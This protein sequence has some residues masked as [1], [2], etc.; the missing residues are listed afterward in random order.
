[1]ASSASGVAVT[2]ST[3][4]L[5]GTQLPSYWDNNQQNVLEG[6]VGSVGSSIEL[7]TTGTG[8]LI[9]YDA[10]GSTLWSYITANINAADNQ[11]LGFWM[12]DAADLLYVVTIDTDTTPDT[13]RLSSINLAG[14]IVNI[15]ND[16]PSVEFATSNAY[17][18]TNGMIQPDGSGGF[19]IIKGSSTAGNDEFAVMD[20]SGTFTTS[21]A[22]IT[23]V[24]ANHGIYGYSYKTDNGYWLYQVTLNSS[25]FHAQISISNE[26]D[27][28]PALLPYN[29][30]NG[31]AISTDSGFIAWRDYVIG[32]DGSSNV[33]RGN[34]KF[35]KAQINAFATQLAAYTGVKI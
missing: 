29:N 9:C 10:T 25:N 2:G 34:K 20:S 4:V 6:F 16:Q 18:T 8:S 24:N 17:W 32:V 33:R 7:P 13:Y 21:P 3:P 11:Y 15:G 30:L 35:T 1:V 5:Q 23:T 22:R 12:N 27:N 28:S 14:T 19:T 31:C 26:T